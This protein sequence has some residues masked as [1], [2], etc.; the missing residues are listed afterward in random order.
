MLIFEY[1]L[2]HVQFCKYLKLLTGHTMSKEDEFELPKHDTQERCVEDYEEYVDNHG[3]TIQKKINH[4]VEPEAKP[5]HVTKSGEKFSLALVSKQAKVKTYFADG[6]RKKTKILAPKTS[7]IHNLIHLNGEKFDFTGRDYL[8]PIYNSNSKYTLLMTGRQVEKSTLLANNLAIMCALQ[9][10][11]RCLYVSPSHVQTRTF[12]NDKLKPVLER[13]PMIARYLQDNKVS[14]QVFEKGF[15]NGAFIFLRSAFFSADRARGI[16]SDLLCYDKNALC[17]TKEGWKRI[18]KVTKEDLVATRNPSTESIEWH[19]PSLIVQKRYSGEM[20]TFKKK[21]IKIR[22]TSDHN[23]VVSYNYLSPNKKWD[24]VKAEDL[25][26]KESRFAMGLPIKDS[27]MKYYYE[28][29]DGRHIKSEKVENEEVYC[30]T[31]KHHQIIVR[32]VYSACPIVCGQ[33]IDELQDMIMGNIPV[34]A[35]CLSHSKHAIHVYAGTPKSYDNTIQQVW[36]T[37]SQNEWMVKCCG[38]NKYNYLDISNIG[39]LGPICKKCGKDLDVTKGQWMK[40]K[41]DALWDGYRIPQLMVPWIAHKGSDAWKS[42]VYQMETYPESQFYNEVLGMSFDNAAKPVTRADI[43]QCCNDKVKFIR[44]PLAMSGSETA[45]VK[46]MTLFAGIDWGEGNDGTGKDIMG[47]IKTASYTVLTIGGY[48]GGRRF[49]VIFSKRYMGKETDPDFIIKDILRICTTMS[50]KMIGADWGH[51]WGMNNKLVRA[52]GP[53]R[54]A[55]FMYVDN[56]K[57]VRKWDPIGF[58]FQLMRNHVMSEVFFAIK[59]GKF[60]FPPLDL[61]EHFA[62]DMLN[63]SVEYIEYQRKLRYVHRPS[64]PDD[65]FHSVVYCKQIADIYHGYQ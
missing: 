60:E 64:D 8:H 59:E 24:L 65:W 37:T 9:P 20:L 22:V 7:W 12:S 23:M 45:F 34:I 19:H 52:V 63:I 54:F 4:T 5:G 13:S 50:V 18:Y 3:Q 14:T 28:V 16:S 57:E 33:C 40:A 62:Q 44:D 2:F 39:K 49:R 27:Q 6:G 32:D 11:F 55:Q 35:Q 46:R 47:K 25:L 1:V 29:F 51:G 53:K 36:E 42:L 31:V 41:K 17:L 48:V 61:W 26:A 56:Q 38:C 43:L 21:G 10:F 15:T 30:L 58:K